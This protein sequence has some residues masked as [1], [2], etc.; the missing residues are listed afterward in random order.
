MS[1]IKYCNFPLKLNKSNKS[2]IKGFIAFKSGCQIWSV[3][4]GWFVRLYNAIS[5]NEWCK[6]S[7]SSS[8]YIKFII[9]LF[10]C[11]VFFSS[12]P[13]VNFFFFWT[14]LLYAFRQSRLTPTAMAQPP[15]GRYTKGGG[16]PEVAS[17]QTPPALCPHSMAVFT[18]YLHP[19]TGQRKERTRGG[20][21]EAHLPPVCT[22][23]WFE[24]MHLTVLRANS[25]SQMV[26]HNC[27]W[28]RTEASV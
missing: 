20:L 21:S 18:G 17:A 9:N 10:I 8:T 14:V 6:F 12:V 1:F 13:A 15:P 23:L 4:I 5:N 25:Y 22:K 2:T 27:R 7:I 24:V 3:I 11:Y 28:G 16:H 19:H 26:I